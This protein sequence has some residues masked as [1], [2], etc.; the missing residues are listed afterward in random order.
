M[1]DKWMRAAHARKCHASTV[2]VGVKFSYGKCWWV[3]SAFDAQVSWDLGLESLKSLLLNMC[4]LFS[5]WGSFFCHHYI[6]KTTLTITY[7]PSQQREHYSGRKGGEDDDNRNAHSCWHILCRVWLDRG[8]EIR[9]IWL[10]I[11][12]RSE[13]YCH[14]ISHLFML[15]IDVRRLLMRRAKST[16][17]ENSYSKG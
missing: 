3:V 12:W 11:P 9:K 4:S 6:S 15:L 16:R 10:L 8:L 7:L 5:P 1:T 17:K 13:I 14:L 2:V